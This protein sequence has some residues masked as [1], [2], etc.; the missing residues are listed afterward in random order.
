VRRRYLFNGYATNHQERIERMHLFWSVWTM[1]CCTILVW[2]RLS[3]FDDQT[4]FP[5]VVNEV[6]RIRLH[7]CS[8]E[9]A[10]EFAMH[11]AAGFP[12]GRRHRIRTYAG[13]SRVSL[14]SRSST[15][16]DFCHSAP[17]MLAVG[18][19]LN[20]RDPRLIPSPAGPRDLR[21]RTIIPASYSNRRQ[22]QA[23]RKCHRALKAINAIVME[24]ICAIQF[25]S[26]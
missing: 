25:P 23:R 10:A 9:L 14:W 1:D 2:Q 6:G 24:G 7:R 20:T 11:D 19:A 5:L 22:R 26:Q 8:A 16:A 21:F 3:A 12:G 15:Y 18:T 17:L 13:I 4:D